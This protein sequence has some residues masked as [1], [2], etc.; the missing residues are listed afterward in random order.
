M[1]LISLTRNVCMTSML[2]FVSLILKEL[3]NNVFSSPCAVLGHSHQ[4]WKVK[5][6]CVRLL[7]IQRRKVTSVSNT[8]CCTS[9]TAGSQNQCPELTLYHQHFNEDA[10]RGK[11]INQQYLCQVLGG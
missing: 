4:N 3:E 5:H 1:S 7:Q 8:A 9:S 11:A 10:V 6:L 2:I